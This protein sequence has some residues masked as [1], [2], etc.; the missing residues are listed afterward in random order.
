MMHDHAYLMIELP[1][2]TLAESLRRHLQAFDVD[3]FE[4]DS[5]WELRIHLFERN[6]ESRVTTALHAIDSWLPTAGV[7]FVRVRLDGSTY[8]LHAPPVP[9]ASW[10]G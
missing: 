4:V 8:T 1:D 5:H 10:A 3:G 9:T 7:E 6:P 2:E